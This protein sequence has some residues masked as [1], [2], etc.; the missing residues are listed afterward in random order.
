MV[1][2]RLAGR[3]RWHRWWPV[4]AAVAE[5]AALLLWAV[6]ARADDMWLSSGFGVLRLAFA[7]ILLIASFGLYI[8]LLVGL[9]AWVLKAMLALS[10]SDAFAYSVVANA[11]SAVVSLIWYVAGAFEGGWKTAMVKGDY[12][13]GVL[14][15]IESYAVALYVETVVLLLALSARRDTK[16]I[17]KASAAANAFSYAV[18]YL[19]LLT[20]AGMGMHRV[21]GMY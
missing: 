3:S 19:I 10:N 6:E 5:G 8:L 7:G 2:V 18:G 16:L 4:V 20:V 17:L 13:H 12:A 21:S 15:M 14:L 1:G 9:E 11:A